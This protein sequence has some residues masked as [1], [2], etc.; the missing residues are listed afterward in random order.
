MNSLNLQN[1]ILDINLNN[2]ELSSIVDSVLKY[3]DPYPIFEL[4]IDGAL[5]I[6]ISIIKNELYLQLEVDNEDIKR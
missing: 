3:D 2:R 1:P 5:I 6:Y 4:A